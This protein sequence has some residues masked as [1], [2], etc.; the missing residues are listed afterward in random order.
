MERRVYRKAYKEFLEADTEK[1][2]E[3]ETEIPLQ[4]TTIRAYTFEN[5]LAFYAMK[6]YDCLHFW[7]S[8]CFI[9]QKENVF[10]PFVLFFLF[11]N[12]TPAKN[13]FF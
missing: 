2:F 13:D 8:T 9:L 10:I 12:G 7:K 5:I 4:P 3:N 1:V 6:D 11:R